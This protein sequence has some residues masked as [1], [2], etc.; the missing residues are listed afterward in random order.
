[1]GGERAFALA[2]E[3]LDSSGDRVERGGGDVNGLKAHSRP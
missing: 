1:M 2:L 3:F